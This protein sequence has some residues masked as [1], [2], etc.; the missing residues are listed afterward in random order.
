LTG[1]DI[2]HVPYKGIAEALTPTMGKAKRDAF[3]Q[4]QRRQISEVV[5]AA[6][7]EVK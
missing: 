2:P 7:I 4:A 5:K 1:I 6:G 3:R